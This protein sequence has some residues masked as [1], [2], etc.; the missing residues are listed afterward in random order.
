MKSLYSRIVLFFVCFV[1]ISF[2]LGT[3]TANIVHNRSIQEHHQ[4]KMAIVTH[5]ISQLTPMINQQEI[6]L[7]SYLEQLSGLGY[8][9]YLVDQ[10]RNTET[11]GRTFK[12]LDLDD[13]YISSVLAGHSYK[14]TDVRPS[15]WL[16][17]I[18][19]ENSLARAEGFPIEWNG[20]TYALFVRPNMLQQLQEVRI[21]LAV[22][23]CASFIFSIVLIIWGTR[24]LVRPLNKLIQ[25]TNHLE[26]G[27]YDVHLDINRGDEIGQLARRFT[28]MASTLKQVDKM[29]KQF[30]ANV[31]H[32]IQSPLTT[33]RGLAEQLYER[34]LPVEQEKQ[35]LQIIAEES[36]RVSELSRQLLTLA[37]LERGTETLKRA[38]YRLD[39]QI[40]DIIIRL[41]PEWSDK[42][43]ELDLELSETIYSG[44][45]GL[46]HQ[47]WSNLLANAIKF[48]ADNGCISVSCQ[49]TINGAVR[50]T[51]ADNGIG[52]PETDIPYVFD[53]FY[54]SDQMNGRNRHGTGLG[55]SIAKRIVDLHEGTIQVESQLNKG[56]VFIIELPQQQA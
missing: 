35:Y 33:I 49:Q 43:L 27:N 19:F 25:A 42:Q 50:V 31:S 14:P 5:S 21:L 9:I 54:K 2:I 3:F 51:V 36:R 7:A 22:L 20:A 52:I 17:P 16:I 23:F 32:E 44:D 24:Y 34:P 13:S 12:H 1:C 45:A 8:Q 28:R 38:P 47:V 55:L 29:R 40:R 15:S 56:T 26:N 30:V 41:E 48:T 6:D 10:D 4:Q 46:L 53:R 39:E 37:A 11:F 18:F